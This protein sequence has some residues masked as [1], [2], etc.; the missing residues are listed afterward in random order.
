MEAR[1]FEGP[2]RTEIILKFGALAFGLLVIVI[3]TAA[4][5]HGFATG[6]N[7]ITSTISLLFAAGMAVLMAF[8]VFR[9]AFPSRPRHSKAPI[10]RAIRTSEK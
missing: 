6:K 1:I 3:A 4:G 7:I 2:S 9:W 8:A 10:D 5:L